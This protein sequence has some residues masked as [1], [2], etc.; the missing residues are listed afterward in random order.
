MA[1]WLNEIQDDI[2][3]RKE[4]L[5]DLQRIINRSTEHPK[6]Q[7]LITFYSIATIYSI[8]ENFLRRTLEEYAKYLNS[9]DRPLFDFSENIIIFTIEHNFSQFIQYPKEPKKKIKFFKELKNTLNDSL[10]LPTNFNIE[11]NLDFITL[12]NYL[13]T[14]EIDK[15]PEMIPNFEPYQN[16]AEWKKLIKEVS[17]ANESWVEAKKFPLKDEL[18]KFVNELRNQVAHGNI[19]GIIIQQSH[20]YRCIRLVEYLFEEVYER[21]KLASENKTYLATTL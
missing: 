7:E 8:W 11:K 9:L 19:R 18:K 12:N 3:D 15:F 1:N 21:V 16:D 2:S 5:S 14:F 20:I 6:E 10:K 4:T 13:D 17:P